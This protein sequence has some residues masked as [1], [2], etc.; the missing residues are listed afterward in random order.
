MI[1]FYNIRGDNMKIL[2]I[3]HAA[4]DITIPLDKFVIENT[5]NR[6]D[7]RVECGGGPASNAAY[8]LGKWGCDVTFMGVVGNDEYGRYIKKELDS[9]NVNTDYLE[10]SSEYKTTSS[11][12]IANK[13][14]GTRT[15]LTYR[16]KEMKMK[17]IDLSFE[18]DIIL[19]DGQEY[20]VSDKIL[21]K[22]PYEISGGQK[23]RVAVARA[24]ITHPD[25]ILADEPTGA[26][27]SKSTEEL[28]RLFSKINENNQTIL[29]VTHS[30]KAASHAQRVLFIKDG[31]VFH[32]IY[33]GDK[34]MDEMYQNISDTLTVLA[35]GGA[36]NE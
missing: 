5:K 33:R 20:N 32:Q 11:F 7:E 30:I 25:L 12:I 8:L 10:L 18:P 14:N 28:L 17:E 3:G 31:V 36:R 16:P 34:S 23:Q 27:D 1:L 26:L 15:I 35:T 21:K 13:S 4:Y 19:V 9:V 2:C 6:V 24:L 29:M 22:Y